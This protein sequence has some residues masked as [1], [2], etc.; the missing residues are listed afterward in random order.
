MLTTSSVA[1]IVWFS[2]SQW[3]LPQLGSTSSGPW[4]VCNWYVPGSQTI[5][6][7]TL[8]M[9]QGHHSLPCAYPAPKSIPAG[10]SSC[11]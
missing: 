1:R 8:H 6:T 2:S 4:P 11:L 5:I 7:S 10:V 9:I 3:E